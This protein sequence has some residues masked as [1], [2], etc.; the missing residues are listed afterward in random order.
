MKKNEIILYTLLWAYVA[1][2]LG[3]WITYI[4]THAHKKTKN[5]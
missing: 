5:I 2:G 3:Y 4:I 1:F